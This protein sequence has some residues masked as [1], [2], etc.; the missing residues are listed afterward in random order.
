[1]PTLPVPFL[2][3][4][5]FVGGLFLLAASTRPWLTLWV[6]LAHVSGRIGAVLA[7]ALTVVATL[8]TSLRTALPLVPKALDNRLVRHLTLL[9]VLAVL[10][11]ATRWVGG[12]CCS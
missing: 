10:G 5:P 1:M 8:L 3:V 11:R 9:A 7:F 4:S 6:F 2:I 12:R